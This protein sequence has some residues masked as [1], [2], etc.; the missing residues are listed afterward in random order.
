VCEIPLV[1]T[2]N[3]WTP[4]Q[5]T[6]STITGAVA[7]ET[8]RFIVSTGGLG[9]GPCP[10]P[11]GGL[12]LDVVVPIPKV[13]PIVADVNGVATWT[14][15]VPATVPVGVDIFLQAVVDRDADSAK[16]NVEA[17]TTQ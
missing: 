10:P 1:L 13:Q 4:G 17:Q 9:N 7:F 11:L 15:T 6:T 5:S 8:V 12:C 16:S 2:T 14:F 3:T